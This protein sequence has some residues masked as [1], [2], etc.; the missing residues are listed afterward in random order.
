[1]G[2]LKY[3][4][5]RVMINRLVGYFKKQ[6]VPV[7]DPNS[8]EFHP[9][10]ETKRAPI[11]YAFSIDDKHYYRFASSLDAPI[12]RLRIM[13]K[14]YR[15]MDMCIDQDTLIEFCDKIL[16]HLNASK[17]IDAG[18]LADE[19]KYRAKFAFEPD[20][21]ARLATCA[22]FTLNEPITDYDFTYNEAKFESFKKK[23][24]LLRYFIQTLAP[25]SSSLLGLSE[26][27]LETYLKTLHKKLA[28]QQALI[29]EE[30]LSE[31]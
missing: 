26:H 17:L 30:K 18:R 13:K 14:F 21:L 7:F 4:K 20:T 8:I 28:L 16:E 10:P 2:L 9:D 22:Y 24:S 11:K 29:S 15:E 25:N 23:D 3:I 12:N 5:N 19:L 31:K 27:D 1:M 6:P